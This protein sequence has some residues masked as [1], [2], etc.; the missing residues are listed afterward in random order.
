M[1]DNDDPYTVTVTIDVLGMLLAGLMLAVLVGFG[2]FIALVL[3]SL[4][5]SQQAVPVFLGF[6]VA[7]GLWVLWEMAR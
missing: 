1:N 3:V 2:W 4:G 7:I 5:L 6:S